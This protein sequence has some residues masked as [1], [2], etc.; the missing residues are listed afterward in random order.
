MSADAHH[1]TAPSEDGEGAARCMLNAIKNSSLALE[2]VNYINAHGT[3]TPLGDIAETIA[4]KRA[5]GNHLRDVVVSSTKFSI[6]H[7]LV[8][9]AELRRFLLLWQLK[10]KLPPYN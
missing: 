2:D 10:I 1:I 3:S 7:L 4:I 6:G 8:L 9:Q 5:L